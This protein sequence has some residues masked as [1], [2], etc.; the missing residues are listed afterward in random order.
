M[1]VLPEEL[2]KLRAGLRCTARELA[3]TLGIPVTEIQAWE[4]GE[5][6]PTKQWV[7]RLEQ[8]ASKGPDAILRSAKRGSK[9]STSALE[10]LDNPELWK[11]VRK[12]LVHPALLADVEKLA[13]S[14]DDPA[15]TSK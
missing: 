9:P 7:S 10:Q 1:A 12:L 14:Y 3:T 4:S 13:A 15:A 6:F 11:I 5:R 2:K 8:L